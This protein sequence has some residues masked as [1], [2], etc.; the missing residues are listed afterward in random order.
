MFEDRLDQDQCTRLVA[1][2]ATTRNPWICAHGRPTMA[3]LALIP[4]GRMSSRRTID[5]AAWKRRSET[6]PAGSAA[7]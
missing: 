4:E 2:L 1:Q 5:W 7:Q 6:T 3:P